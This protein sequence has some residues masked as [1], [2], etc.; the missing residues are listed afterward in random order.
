M[1]TLLVG[2]GSEVEIETC[3]IPRLAYEYRNISPGMGCGNEA[4]NAIAKELERRENGF[5]A[6]VGIMQW[7]KSRI[8]RLGEQHVQDVLSASLESWD[9][10]YG[11][12]Y[13]ELLAP[14]NDASSR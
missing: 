7:I 3:D 11:K 9:E 5:Q 1:T 8:G 14:L 12:S 4:L 2:L 10:K 13:L 6:A